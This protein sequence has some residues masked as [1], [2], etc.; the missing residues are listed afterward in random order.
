MIVI[1]ELYFFSFL[2]V[3]FYITSSEMKELSG[4]LRELWKCL[5]S[6]FNDPFQDRVIGTSLLQLFVPI[7]LKNKG[8]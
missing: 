7:S 8:N 1:Y 6:H 4:I 5:K 3:A 2:M